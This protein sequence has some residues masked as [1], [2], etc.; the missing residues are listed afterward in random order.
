VRGADLCYYSFARLPRGPL[1]RGYGP[2]VPELVIEVRSP[3]DRWPNLHAT[4]AEY[5]N[6]GVLAVVVLDPDRR[7]AHLFSADDPPRTLAAEEELAL[8]AILE[9]FRVGVARFF[10]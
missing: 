6:A 5:L 4:I 2:E 9:G 8:P 1:S 10:E 7:A 3:S